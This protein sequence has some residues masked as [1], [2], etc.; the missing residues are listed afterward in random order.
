MEAGTIVGCL[1]KV[2][3]EV[4]KGDVIFEVETE[5]ATLEIESPVSGY[6]R[7]VLAELEQTL[8][9]GRVLLV[10]G[11]KDEKVPQDYIDS[12]KE[13]E[14]DAGQSVLDD[15]VV[16]TEPETELFEHDGTE[17]EQVDVEIKLGATVPLTRRRKQIAGQMVK[18]KRNIP[19]FYLTSKADVTQLAELKA[20]LSAGG[21]DVSYDDFIIKALGAAL[22]KFAV[23]T[24]QIEDGS[25]RLADAIN[26]GFAV[27][28]PN[29][30][31]VPVV[32]D[33][34][35]K[36]VGQI[37]E[38][39]RLLTQKALNEKLDLKESEGACITISNPG[40]QGIDT[41]IPIVVPGQCSGLGVGKINEQCVPVHGE[42]SVR[43]IMNLSI[44]VDH[45]I[46]SGEY[47]ARFL[48]TLKKLLEDTSTFTQ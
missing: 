21:T 45:K 44:S 47:A 25:V 24:G 16:E 41:F 42:T 1:V 2:G 35:K 12:L 15:G 22:K 32:T 19:C 40:E 5:K 46:V 17:P 31:L 29:G 36:D 43:K 20:E 18:S 30:V 23:M 4:N 11:D 27:D 8:P 34:D 7:H 13:P 39:K 3:D 48:D 14:A 6:V 10:V 26:I 33:V 37:A 38:E 28:A 9:V